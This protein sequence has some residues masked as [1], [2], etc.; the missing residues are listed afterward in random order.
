M[1]S[2]RGDVRRS[3]KKVVEDSDMRSGTVAWEGET[4]FEKKNSL[5]FVG[6][7]L[8]KLTSHR[9]SLFRSLHHPTR[10]VALL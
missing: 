10:M 3:E 8:N 6:E 2:L 7:I 9:I 1:G 4:L 5:K